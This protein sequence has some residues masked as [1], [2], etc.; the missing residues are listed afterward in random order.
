MNSAKQYGLVISSVLAVSLGASGCANTSIATPPSA[1]DP[2]F[3]HRWFPLGRAI[4]FSILKVVLVFRIKGSPGDK[5]NQRF[6][7]VSQIPG[8]FIGVSLQWT[9]FGEIVFRIW[10]WFASLWLPLVS[11]LGLFNGLVGNHREL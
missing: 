10:R 8:T 9:I 11:L 7:G 6:A 4:L 3:I 1:T 2:F 5:W